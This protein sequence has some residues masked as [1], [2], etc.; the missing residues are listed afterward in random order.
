MYKG[1]CQCQAVQFELSDISEDELDVETLS[2][3]ETLNLTIAGAREHLVIDCAPSMLGELQLSPNSKQFFCNECSTPIFTED[4]Q[5]N[6]GLHVAFYGHDLL[7]KH[8]S[9]YH[10]P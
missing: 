7:A 4:D 6:I 2:C 3:S 5:G 1:S 9:Q 10:I 8:H